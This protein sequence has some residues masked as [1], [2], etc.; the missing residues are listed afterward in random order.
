[1]R[2][3][4][5][6]CCPAFSEDT[7]K[8]RTGTVYKIC[9]S[10]L[11]LLTLVMFSGCGN[12]VKTV[13]EPD[14][15]GKDFSEYKTPGSMEKAYD[16]SFFFLPGQDKKG[17]AYVG[18]TMPYYEDGKYYI[19]Y[20]KDGGDSYNH[21][22]YLAVTE[23]FVSYT[24]YPEPVLESDRGGGQD[25]WIGTG[26]VIKVNGEYLFFYTGHAAS[27]H[28]EYKEVIMLAKGS[29]P[30]KFEKVED[31]RITPP[32]SLGQK[33]DFRDPEAQYDEATGK[34]ILTVTAAQGGLARILKFTTDA[35]GSNARYDGIIFTDPAGKFWNLEC[36]D[37]FSIGGKHYI[38]YSAQD[39]TLWYAVSDT[40][41]GPYSG[42]S[43]LDGKLFYAAKHV[44]GS[45]G[46]YMIGWAR[47]SESQSSTQ[48]VSAWAGNLAVQR[49]EAGEDGSLYL[50]PAE[51]IEAGFAKE[52]TVY[53]EKGQVTIEAGSAFSYTEC[54]TAYERF[55]LKGDM[56]FTGAGDFGL[57]FDFNGKKDKY[58]LIDF[59]PKENRLKLM[60]NEGMTPIT[61]TELELEPG[62]TYPFTYIQEGSVGII[63]IGDKAA[64]TVRL[65]GVSGKAISLYAANNTVVFSNLHE[66]IK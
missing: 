63:Y 62:V 16:Y 30:Y 3:S 20:L 60:F 13:P 42:A 2:G 17:Q 29:T 40:P 54:F 61:E 50:V 18:D 14:P 56:T 8:H 12:D 25:A 9:S 34:I 1:M 66:Y 32:D 55:M 33:R 19:Y 38:T 28:F 52:C 4:I 57:A 64:L 31:Y 35:D 41:Y 36:S 44:K 59:C 65:Y 51:N 11:I 21:S 5:K 15:S 49:I 43:R 47:R 23:D 46:D 37:T 24:E 26:S 6:H 58:K 27:D 48:D 7:M 10:L 45:S 39:D 22:V 53:P